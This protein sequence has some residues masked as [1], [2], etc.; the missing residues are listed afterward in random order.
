VSQ[1]DRELCQ[2]QRPP[3]D[4]FSQRAAQRGVGSRGSGKVFRHRGSVVHRQSSGE[5]ARRAHHHQ[6]Q[7]GNRPD[8]SLADEILSDGQSLLFLEV[9]SKP[10]LLP[11]DGQKINVSPLTQP[12]PSRGEEVLKPVLLCG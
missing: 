6:D 9:I 4:Q 5:S 10:T 2:T 7:S 3:A 8:L 11:E 1:S 12:L